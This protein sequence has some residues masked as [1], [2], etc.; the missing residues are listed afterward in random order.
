MTDFVV[1]P[2]WQGSASSRAMRLIDG[3]LAIAGDLPRSATTIVAAPEEAGDAL[4]TG[5]RRL[6]ALRAAARAH[7]EAAR[8]ATGRVVTIGG[9]AGVGTVAALHGAGEGSAVLWLSAQPSLHD[10]ESSPTGAYAS[11][12]ARALV[13]PAIPPL[14]AS[15]VLPATHVVIA[16]ARDAAPAEIAAA[17]ALGVT[18]LP[19]VEIEPI[20]AAISA[21]RPSSLHIH[22]GVD[23]LDPAAIAGVTDPVPFGPDAAAL[24]GAIRAARETAPAGSASLTGFSPATPDAAADDM[25]TLLRIIGALA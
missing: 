23:V 20:V 15:T 9:D 14:G 25:G 1:V 3:A 19:T 21:A 16:G 11:M 12:A 13:D 2:Q 18:L 10:V 22:V 17:D 4:G 8:P 5:V 24:I 7:A 6:S